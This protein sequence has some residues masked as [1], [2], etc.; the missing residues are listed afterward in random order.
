[1]AKKTKKQAFTIVELVIVIAV[2][3]ILAAILIPTYSNLV[4]KANEA[5]ALADA[6]N[7]ITEMLADILSGD[8]DA[9]DLIVFS[10]KGDAVYAHG[11]SAE[12]GRIISYSKNPEEL[13]GAAFA[14]KVSEMLTQ[15]KNDGAITPITT[16]GEND[17]R[18]ADNTAQTVKDLGFNPGEMI[19]RA[20]YKI[21]LDKFE[22]HTHT[23]GAWVY[24]GANHWHECTVCH[25]KA[26][27]A[28]HKYENGKCV[29]G[30]A[31]PGATGHTHTFDK[32][33]T[34][35]TYIASPATC[36][37]AAKYYYS[38]EC[39]TSENNA[40]HIFTSGSALGHSYAETAKTPATCIATGLR[41]LKCTRCNDEKT[42]TIARVPHSY[43]TEWEKDETSHWHEC[44]E[45]GAKTGEAAHSFSG[46]TCSVCGREQV[47]YCTGEHDTY[48]VEVEPTCISDGK[49]QTYCRKC[50]YYNVE[51]DE[52][53]P[54]VPY[55]HK[56]VPDR[57][58]VEVVDG[59]Q[60]Y[61]LHTGKCQHCNA[62]FGNDYA[63]KILNK[64]IDNKDER[65]WMFAQM[66]AHVLTPGTGN[67]KKMNAFI[68]NGICNICGREPIKTVEHVYDETTHECKVCGTYDYNVC[69]AETN[70]EHY[71]GDW[72]VDNEPTCTTGGGRNKYCTKCRYSA[73]YEDIP[74]NGHKPEFIELTGSDKWKKHKFTCKVCGE[75]H[76]DEHTFVGG[77][78]NVCGQSQCTHEEYTF[79]KWSCQTGNAKIICATCEKTIMDNAYANPTHHVNNG[80]TTC[81]PTISGNT[82]N[83][84]QHKY[85]SG[86]CTEC[87]DNVAN[88]NEFHLFVPITVGTL[89]EDSLP[90][91]YKCLVCNMIL[92]SKSNDWGNIT[93]IIY[94]GYSTK[95][96]NKITDITAGNHGKTITYDNK[97]YKIYYA[98]SDK[99]GVTSVNDFDE[100]YAIL[101]PQG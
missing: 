46:G 18:T 76:T 75:T 72:V 21:A 33:N 13:N 53:R 90:Y 11:Y 60:T 82:I 40:S 69:E 36:T 4:K 61:V 97:N 41:T 93:N 79:D 39:G 2:I 8:K 44:T 94:N 23:F 64:E 100:F 83:F 59:E 92:F 7:L 10:K 42:E 29:C 51:I 20:D 65:D 85:V 15:M 63:N 87:K 95:D 45:C 25:E 66:N 1:M 24:D 84:G 3:A 38:C 31:D 88:K 6:K 91:G 49:I 86:T 62:S 9:A 67:V 55:A 96:L 37:E 14:D 17:W 12:A 89:Q 22:K 78:C 32:E 71:L 16:S 5:T 43:G 56:L 70:G 74:A 57:G 58:Y 77:K 68:C 52:T 34:A 26:D 81:N 47:Q 54:A 73:A 98:H 101:I 30:A 99:S 28:A 27:E 35:D 48:T 50:P 19:V 80:R